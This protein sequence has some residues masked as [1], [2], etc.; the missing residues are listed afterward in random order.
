MEQEGSLSCSEPE[1]PQAGPPITLLHKRG[2]VDSGVSYCR[3]HLHP[4]GGWISRAHTVEENQL[5][6]MPSDLYI[7]TIVHT[8]PY[9]QAHRK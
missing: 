3:A 6:K 9:T 7:C 2:T 5:A 8:C 4:N 1:T